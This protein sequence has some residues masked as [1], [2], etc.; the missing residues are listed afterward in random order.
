MLALG[1]GLIVVLVSIDQIS[2]LLI[3]KHMTIGQEIPFIKNVLSIT[4][5][6]NTGAAWGILGDHTFL[7][8]IVSIVA[9]GFMGYMMKD[10]NLRT[11]R[12]YSISMIM[13]IAGALGN[14]IDRV[15]RQE[16]VDFLKFEFIN[17]PIFNFADTLL[18]IGVIIFLIDYI[19]IKK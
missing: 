13:L 9:L 14:L 11:N 16:V 19:L 8:T 4:S 15:F 3:I 6:R 12:W 18:T 1:I 7:L 10:F 17:F 5:H 2:K